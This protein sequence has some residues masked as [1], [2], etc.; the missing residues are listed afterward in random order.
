MIARLAP[1]LP[2][3]LRAHAA[4]VAP[5]EACGAL[6]GAFTEAGWTVRRAAPLPNRAPSHLR[7]VAYAIDPTE[8]HAAMAS[9]AMA[10]LT[11]PSDDLVG[12]YHSHPDG[13]ARPSAAD[14]RAAPWPGLLC[15]ILGR[16]GLRAY[17]VPDPPDHA[18]PA[19]W[20]PV[21]L[22]PMPTHRS[23]PCP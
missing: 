15:L 21:P 6:F 13:P 12:W 23:M 2:A 3:A 17:A 19:P 9:L 22:D 7:R 16:D 14:R 8:L 10:S 18:S 5:E 11:L 4:R 20:P 1:D